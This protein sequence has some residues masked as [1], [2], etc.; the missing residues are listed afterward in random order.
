MATAKSQ[1]KSK[2]PTRPSA[3]TQPKAEAQPQAA[4]ERTDVLTLAEAAAFLRVKQEDLAELAERNGVPA[5]K[6]ATEWRFLRLA[7]EYW[8][9]GK[10]FHGKEI[11]QAANPLEPEVGF[12]EALLAQWGIFPDYKDLQEQLAYHKA[13][14]EAYR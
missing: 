7:L 5:Q 4:T 14:R 2:T 12:K 1:A 11:N 6:I 10:Q 9:G 8:L 13:F 3:E